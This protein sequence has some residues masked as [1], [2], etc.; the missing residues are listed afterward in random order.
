MVDNHLSVNFAKLWRA[1]ANWFGLK[2][3]GPSET[4]DALKPGEM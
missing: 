3:V 2:E 4:G 1:I